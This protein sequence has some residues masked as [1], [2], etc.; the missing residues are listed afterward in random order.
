M[1]SPKILLISSYELGHQP[2]S[3]AWPQALLVQNAYRVDTIDLAVQRLPQPPLPQY[4]L[5]GFSVPM[6]T[7]LRL[8]VPAAQ[9][10][11]E[12]QNGAH[13]VFFGLYAGLNGEYLLQN[14][15]ADSVIA[16]ESE[17]VLLELADRLQD[18]LEPESIPG[19]KTAGSHALTALS[20][21]VY[22]V[23]AREGLPALSE[24][25]RFEQNGT[26]LQTGY[27]ETTRGC[28]HTCAHCPVVP[29]YK[30]RF[31]AIPREIVL[32]DI[33]QQIAMGARHITFGDPD[34]L[35]GPG[36]A[37]QVAKTLHKEFPEVS[38]DFTAKVSHL[39]QYSDL[40]AELRDHGAAFVISAF[41]S[42]S[43]RVLTRL[44]KGHSRRDLDRAVEAC[45]S[46]DLAIQPTF[47]PFTPWGSL[48]D[49]I[50]MLSWIRTR[51]LI[52]NVPTVQYSVR[53]LVPPGSKLLEHPDCAEWL[54]PLEPEHFSY[55]WQ[56][57][58]PEMD[59]LFKDV[60]QIAEENSG[61]SPWESFQK[62]EHAAYQRAGEAPP[63]WMIPE[64]PPPAPPRLTED[65]FC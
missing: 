61:C 4:D 12:S 28:K 62:I 22:P 63:V 46:A 59:A 41:E 39:I 45:K 33:R 13:F 8:A 57:P 15:I 65:W 42:T 37:R 64:R 5:V 60:F 16:G 48:A 24:Y 25:T 3:L 2:L 51:E 30:G 53:M 44:E 52:P 47:L 32:A 35:N 55:S 18:G 17:P 1:S 27:T 54:G 36:H 7:A 14:G 9:R 10:L 29:V 23:P 38:F 26:V 11:R 49:Y 58:E 40:L 21:W 43:D 6:H 19:L 34:F 20:R 50:D 31:F 56:H